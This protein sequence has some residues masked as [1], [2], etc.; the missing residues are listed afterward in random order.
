MEERGASWELLRWRG[1]AAT[2]ARERPAGDFFLE[3]PRF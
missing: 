2:K 3:V 1:K